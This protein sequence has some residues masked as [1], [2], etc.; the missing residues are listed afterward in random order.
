[1]PRLPRGENRDGKFIRQNPSRSNS[2]NYATTF[3]ASLM[4]RSAFGSLDYSEAKY[5]RR[6]NWMIL[7]SAQVVTEEK[8]T[9]AL[10]IV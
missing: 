2:T 4:M 1:M 10:C 9:K 8:L 7:V 5:K 6:R 3:F